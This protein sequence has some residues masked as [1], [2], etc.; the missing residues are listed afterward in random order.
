MR[1]YY[2]CYYGCDWWP[3][4]LAKNILRPRR[5][6]TRWWYGNVWRTHSIQSPLHQHGIQCWPGHFESFARVVNQRYPL[7]RHRGVGYQ[8]EGYIPIGG[9]VVHDPMILACLSSYFACSPVIREPFHH[10]VAIPYEDMKPTRSMRAADEPFNVGWHY[11]TPNLVQLVILLN[12]VSD[13]D[14]HMQYARGEHRRLRVN[15]TKW[16]YYY[17]DEYAERH[18]DVVKCVGPIGTAYLFDTNAP[19]RFYMVK[20]SMRAMIKVGYTPGNAV[21]FP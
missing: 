12:D 5:F 20:D 17:S 7:S 11:D 9:D 4:L 8:G 13:T 6:L 21:L 1:Q 14:S 10:T 18:F 15:L 2:S 19:H 16:D 3:L